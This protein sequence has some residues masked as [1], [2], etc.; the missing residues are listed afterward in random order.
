MVSGAFPVRTDN[1]RQKLDCGL[2]ATYA[3]QLSLQPLMSP[4]YEQSGSSWSW[5]QTESNPASHEA[6]HL[7]LGSFG[8]IGQMSYVA[9]RP[10]G[11]WL[12]SLLKLAQTP[13]ALT[14][15]LPARP[16]SAS[17]STAC[18][19]S[20]HRKHTPHIRRPSHPALRSWTGP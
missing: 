16:F 6:Q 8:P 14:H 1:R 9:I 12:A 4:A 18:L 2:G 15:R 17:P 11:G 20:Q 10:I 5:D 13:P 3:P 19:P 7:R